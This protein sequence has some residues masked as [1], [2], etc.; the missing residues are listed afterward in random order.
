LPRLESFLKCH[1]DADLVRTRPFVPRNDDLITRIGANAGLDPAL[2]HA[3]NPPAPGYFG[4][5]SFPEPKKSDTNQKRKHAKCDED[6][7]DCMIEP[8]PDERCKDLDSKR[9]ASK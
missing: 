1:S 5:L 4:L 9:S 2:A 3:D 7:A 8:W 6:Y